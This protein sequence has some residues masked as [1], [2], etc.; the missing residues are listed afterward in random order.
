MSDAVPTPYAG[1][2]PAA[3]PGYPPPMG[4]HPP[5]GVGAPQVQGSRTLAIVGLVLAWCFPPAGLVVSLVALT[6]SRRGEQARLLAVLGVVA[7]VVLT[8]VWVVF[9]ALAGEFLEGLREVM[10]GEM[11]G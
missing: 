4:Y 9:F 10:E 2:Q 3:P 5:P 7:N 1:Q 11:A 8:V 6:Q